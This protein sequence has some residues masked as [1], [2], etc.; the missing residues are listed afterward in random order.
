[1]ERHAC[2]ISP[3]SIEDGALGTPQLIAGGPAESIFQ[4]EWSPDGGAIVFVSDRSGWWNL[5]RFDLATR[6]TRPLAPMAAEFG[7]PQWN[8]GTS[9]YAFAGADRIVCAYSERGLGRLAVLDLKDEAL[10]PLETP[11]TEFGSV[12]AAATA[13]CFAPAAPDHPASI[14][15]LDLGSGRARRS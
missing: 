15:V 1:M 12:R 14:V 8:L 4:P 11:F 6:T 7:L 3:T 5:Y 13:S 10:R 9:T 2:S